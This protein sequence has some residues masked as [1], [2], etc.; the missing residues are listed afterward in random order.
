[1]QATKVLTTDYS[2]D[3]LSTLLLCDLNATPPADTKEHKTE[4]ESEDMAKKL[5]QTTVE[6]EERDETSK[7][8]AADTEPAEADGAEATKQT[9]SKNPL[10][11]FGILSP[12]SLR[13][14]Q[15]SASKLV[16]TAVKLSIVDMEMKDVEIEIRRARKRKRKVKNEKVVGIEKAK[17]EV[18][19]EE[20][21][22][23]AKVNRGGGCG[24]VAI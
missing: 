23:Q 17:G 20:V 21:H 4:N 14:A 3:G 15:S 18:T 19:H 7:S 1:M 6:S 9:K 10:R 16:E 8:P 2:E 5:E 12:P 22:R 13:Q 11:W 24:R